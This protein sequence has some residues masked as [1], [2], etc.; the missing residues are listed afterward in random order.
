MN[1]KICIIN[2]RNCTD[3][4]TCRQKIENFLTNFLKRHFEVAVVPHPLSTSPPLQAPNSIGCV[5]RTCTICQLCSRLLIPTVSS[6][7]RP[8]TLHW[9][10]TYAQFFKKWHYNDVVAKI[11]YS[12]VF[13]S[14][15]RCL[16]T[17]QY[18]YKIDQSSHI[19]G[20]TAYNPLLFLWA[21]TASKWAVWLS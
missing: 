6:K 20:R 21:R 14:E 5:I 4:R 12:N 11:E 1:K 8:V 13:L 15:S 2:S 18:V 7:C 19:F 9:K 16:R 3:W 17:C 10:N